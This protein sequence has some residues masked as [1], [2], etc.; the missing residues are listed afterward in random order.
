MCGEPTL[1]RRC[2]VG[3]GVVQDEVHV[4]VG[5]D[6]GVDL[7]Q[8]RQELGGAVAGVQRPDDLPGREIQGGIQAGGAVADVVVAG[9]RRICGIR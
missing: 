1:Y 6:L 3:R 2:L 9:P 7:A 5:G 8:E 4:E